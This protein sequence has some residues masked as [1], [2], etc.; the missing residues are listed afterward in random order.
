MFFF[1]HECALTSSKSQR[2]GIKT[3]GL[4]F[5]KFMVQDAHA[6]FILDLEKM[7]NLFK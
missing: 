3:Q 2:I 4:I 1:S 5:V 6:S 7:I